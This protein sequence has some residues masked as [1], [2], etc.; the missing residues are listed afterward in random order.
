[1]RGDSGNDELLGGPGDDVLQGGSEDDFL[2]GGSGN[3]SLSGDDGD[4]ILLGG[5]GADKLEGGTGKDSTSYKDSHDRV[6]LNLSNNPVPILLPNGQS[7]TV[8]ARSASGGDADG[9]TFDGSIENIEGS[10]GDDILI[11]DDST[12][13][14]SGNTLD[15]GKGN[16]TL[17]GGKGNDLLFGGAGVDSLDGGEGEDGT[18][19]INSPAYV[20]INL[21]TGEASGGDAEGE[22]LT[23]IE[24]VQGS[25]YNDILIGNAS[26]NSL[27]GSSGDDT[28]TGG[29][30]ADT[31]DGSDG[32]DWVSYETSFHGVNVS[33]KTGGSVLENPNT[34]LDIELSKKGHG[35]DAEGDVLLK[36]KDDK[37]KDTAYYSFENL[38]GSLD[39]DTLEG[40]VRDNI[41][42]GLDGDDTLKG[43]G[44]NDT[45]MGGLKPIPWM[46]GTA[47]I[48]L[49]IAIQQ[50]LSTLIYKQL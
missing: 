27:N 18:T 43:D 2:D 29:G 39:N 23:S 47:L 3:D 28:L 41:L 49:T 11:G 4:D 6:I 24:D 10:D 36:A 12:D 32:I 1:L 15:G 5:A 31:L 25:K 8:A 38:E 21:E 9:D 34:F 13:P 17:K 46:V 19:Y 26:N 30:G 40:D 45:L 20:K 44:G 14:E 42:K 35:G 7:I 48:G 22:K 16:D 50:L 33:L 37:G